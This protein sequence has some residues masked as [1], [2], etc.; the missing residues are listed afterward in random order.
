MKIQQIAAAKEWSFLV[1]C[2]IGRKIYYGMC[3]NLFFCLFKITQGKAFTQKY[4]SK[5]AVIEEFTVLTLKTL[6]TIDQL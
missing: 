1:T 4:F 2:I 5:P 3:R 6:K